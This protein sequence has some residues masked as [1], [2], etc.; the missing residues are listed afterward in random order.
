MFF[1]NNHSVFAARNKTSHVRKSP[2]YRNPVLNT[3][4]KFYFQPVTPVY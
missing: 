4:K 3:D 1:Q 2:D